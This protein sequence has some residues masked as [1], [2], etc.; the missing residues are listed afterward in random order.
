M[1]TIK[2]K[3]KKK[4][5]GNN[6]LERRDAKTDLRVPVDEQDMVGAVCRDHQK[7]VVGKAV[8]RKTKADWVD[9]DNYV[10]LVQFHGKNYA[11][12]YLLPPITQKQIRYFDDEKNEGRFAPC[13][14]LL[15]APRH[16]ARLTHRPRHDLSK[17][18]SGPKRK[19]RLAPT[20]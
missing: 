18:H 13:E 5:K 1:K 16:S 14:V 12:R 6:Q 4:P 2:Q 11:S 20:R 3:R 17:K 19:E 9:V 15:K 7:C 10:V 8:K